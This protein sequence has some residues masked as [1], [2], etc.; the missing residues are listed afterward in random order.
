MRLL[1][2]VG[3][4][5][6]SGGAAGEMAT[7]RL[8]EN[9]TIT[10][11]AP[12]MS[13][14]REMAEHGRYQYVASSVGQADQR[15]TLSVHVEPIDCRFGKSLEQVARCFNER[16]DSIPGVIKEADSPSCDRK[17]CD[18]FYVLSTKTGDRTVRQLNL[19]SL[20]VYGGA[21]VDVHL[22]VLNPVAEDAQRL[23]RFAASLKF[24]E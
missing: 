18:V 7:L 10:F 11:D 14:L 1:I 3:L 4:L 16:L 23:A 21:W 17:R 6:I 2:A 19:N 5:L 24:A 13:K 22:S 9:A 20:F 8:P 12:K 15:F